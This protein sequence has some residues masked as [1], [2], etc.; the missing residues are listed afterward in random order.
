V[1]KAPENV[2]I[3]PLALCESRQVGTGTRID[4]FAHILPGARIGSHCDLGAG[5][6]I[7]NNVV[8]GD[9]VTVKNGVV[10]CE[11]AILE[12]EVFV[13][14]N[15]T[16]SDR[17]PR[18]NPE[19]P[20]PFKTWIRKRAS[21]GANATLLAGITVGESA[22]IGAGCVV[23][24][25]VPAGAIVDG[26]PV[27]IVDYVGAPRRATSGIAPTRGARS[28]QRLAGG[29]RL[30]QFPKFSD[31]R[32]DLTVAELG[33]NLPFL[34]KR[35][36]FTYNVPSDRVRGEHAHRECCQVYLAIN[37]VVSIVVDDGRQCD[38][39]VLEDPSVGLLI[40]PK[41]WTVQYRFS[42]NAVLAVFASHPYQPEDYIRDY[43]E[44]ER[45]VTNPA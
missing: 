10:L 5:I 44:F 33:T 39:V 14:P 18:S 24:R 6:V 36:F 37:G 23:T 16:F 4:A 1:A 13:G 26:N 11:G 34:P 19:P 22:T 3:H 20:A 7:E 12:D 8:I 21:I 43:S 17:F 28:G 31:L 41:V 30:W 15:A 25:D 27:R 40:P 32:G 38:E 9:R 2:F 45:F 35:I 29:C 42:Q